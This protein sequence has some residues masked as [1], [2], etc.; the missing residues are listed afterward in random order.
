MRPSTII[1]DQSR[2]LRLRPGDTGLA[3]SLPRDH[4]T[5]EKYELITMRQVSS[6]YR[7]D[8]R[9]AGLRFSRL[10]PGWGRIARYGRERSLQP[11]TRRSSAGRVFARR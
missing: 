2:S 6:Y 10:C 8:V 7:S 11:G 4:L 1:A 9:I 3:A 5:K